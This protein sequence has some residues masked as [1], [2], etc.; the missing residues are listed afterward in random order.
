MKAM[1]K[2]LLLMAMLPLVACSKDNNNDDR[3]HYPEVVLIDNAS[4]LEGWSTYN[5]LVPDPAA[6]IKKHC[7]QVVDVLYFSS[8]D[9][10]I[11]RV[12]RITYELTPA[13]GV[14]DK[15]GAPPYITIRY[16]TA[17]AR[18]ATDAQ[19]M[20][21]IEGVLNHELTHAYQLEPKG[22]GTYGDGGAYWAFIEGMADAV[23]P[24]LGPFA[25]GRQPSKGGTYLSGYSTTGWFLKWLR[26]TK[27]PDFLRKF[28]RTAAEIN[29]WSW[30]KAMQ[31]IFGSEVTTESLWQEYQES[32]K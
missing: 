1:K 5:R 13:V 12:D 27:D 25:D 11:P 29:P 2:L 10:N 23:R 20:Q 17:N 26:D 14:S 8:T 32:I 7:K 3:F 24:V 9:T 16:N 31:S 28:N 19:S 22:A 15:S 21:E 30:D 6:L 18:Q 4:G